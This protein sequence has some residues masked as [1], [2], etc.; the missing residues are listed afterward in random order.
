MGETFLKWNNLHM[1]QRFLKELFKLVEYI[2]IMTDY[3]QQKRALLWLAESVMKC[4]W[5]KY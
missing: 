2:H 4:L 1:M 3:M 5:L